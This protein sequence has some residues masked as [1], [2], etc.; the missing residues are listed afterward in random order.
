MATGENR[1]TQFERKERHVLIIITGG[2]ICMQD[3]PDGLVPTRDF[4]RNCLQPSPDFNDG[5]LYEHIPV[6]N[7]HGRNG[8][9]TTLRAPAKTEKASTYKYSVFE[10]ADLIDSS[11]MDGGH[12]NL[13]LKCLELN[14]HQFDAFVVL[15][16]TDTLAYTASMLAFIL[17]ELQK[18]VIITGAQLSMY[19]P[20]NDAHDN[21]L[22]SLTVAAQ[23]NIPEV[24]VVF[25]HNL[26]RATR[27]T[28]VSAFSMAAFTTPNA[29][30][31]ASFSRHVNQPW[32]ANLHLGTIAPAMSNDPIKSS[33]AS[34]RDGS[35]SNLDTGRVAVLKVYP[36]ISSSLIRSIIQM[37]DLGGLILETFGAGNI[38][39]GTGGKGLLQ[40]LSTAV[41]MGIVVVSVTQCKRMSLIRN[42]PTN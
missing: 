31:L 7:E 25:H 32:T 24:G 41:R 23:Y 26:Y 19:A 2:T 35:V 22:D 13:I 21:L 29:K 40:T 9:A 5:S 16:G 10:F 30:P 38:P 15:H 34:P 6:T 11:N 1:A 27:V 39:I 14:W 42:L 28:K 36:G 20:H 8:I 12:W 18:T 3:S 37:P 4:V 17:G 33:M